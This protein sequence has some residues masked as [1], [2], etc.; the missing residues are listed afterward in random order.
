MIKL[1]SNRNRDN[2]FAIMAKRLKSSFLKIKGE[3]KDHLEAIN[4]NSREIQD[5]YEQICEIENKIEKLNEKVDEMCLFLNRSFNYGGSS[6]RNLDNRC[7]IELCQKEK[8]IFLV[9]YTTEEGKPV[10]YSD[11]AEKI[12]I[13]ENL[14][15]EYVLSMVTKGIPINK[16]V[17]NSKVILYLDSNFRQEQA[18]H[19]LLKLNESLLKWFNNEMIAVN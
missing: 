15:R 6:P 16:I 17:R 14:A 3:L 2:R 11:I 10:Y 9:L 7:D 5:N 12:G 19:N 13:S 8:E 1:L 4:D 18:K